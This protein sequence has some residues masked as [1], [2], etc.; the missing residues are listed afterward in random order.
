M[1]KAASRNGDQPG[2]KLAN[3]LCFAIYSAAHAFNSV[4]KPL[5]DAIDLTYPQYLFMLVLWE[6]DGRTLKEIGAELHLDSGTL[7]PLL[8]RMESAGVLRR[9]RDREDERQVRISL[10]PQGAALKSKAAKFPAAIGCAAQAAGRDLEKLHRDVVA[11]R[12]A[13]NAAVAEKDE[14]TSA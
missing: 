2:L 13:L 11:L 6:R 7:T 1:K 12:D 14:R 4:Y 3:Q 10:T 5:L 9:V 8:K